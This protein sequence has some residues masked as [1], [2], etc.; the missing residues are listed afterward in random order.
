MGFKGN[1]NN[2][3][4]CYGFAEQEAVHKEVLHYFKISFFFKVLKSVVHLL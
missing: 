1:L 2:T 3:E 4:K